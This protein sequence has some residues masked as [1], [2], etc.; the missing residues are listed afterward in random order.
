MGAGT[1]Y[2]KEREE[3]CLSQGSMLAGAFSITAE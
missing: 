2:L 1:L 3:W